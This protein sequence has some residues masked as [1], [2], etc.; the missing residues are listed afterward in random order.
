MVPG[1]KTTYS[2]RKVGEGGLKIERYLHVNS[3]MFA[4]D[5]WQNSQPSLNRKNKYPQTQSMYLDNYPYGEG[6][7]AKWLRYWTLNHEIVGSS[8]AIH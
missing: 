5:I 1:F 7:M 6:R 8:P 2:T 4:R 3:L